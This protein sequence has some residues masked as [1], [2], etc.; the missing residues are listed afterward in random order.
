MDEP[1][2]LTAARFKAQDSLS[3]VDA[4][5]VAFAVCERAVLAHKNAELERLARKL[6][7]EIL[8]YE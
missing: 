4:M 2:L 6:K 7:Q 1:T 3:L 8:P 5:I